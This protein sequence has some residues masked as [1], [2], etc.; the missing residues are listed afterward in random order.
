MAAEVESMFY[1]R[2]TPWHGLGTRVEDAPTSED[3]LRLAG[4]DWDVIQEKIFTAN[5]NIVKDYYANIRSSDHKVLGV[6]SGRYQIVQNRDAFA[7]T[8]ELLGKGVQ[9]ET[10][11]ARKEGR[12]S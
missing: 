12:K 3:A 1:V 4:L 11:G 10:A 7:F 2:E 5:G 6:V 8:D 9:Y